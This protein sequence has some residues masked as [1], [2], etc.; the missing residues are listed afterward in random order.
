MDVW[1]EFRNASKHQ[2]EGLFRNFFPAAEEIDAEVPTQTL[3]ATSG[4][5]TPPTVP[6]TPAPSSTPTVSPPPFDDAPKSLKDTLPSLESA[7][8][9]GTDP[10]DAAR[11]AELAKIF[12]DS[13]P[14]EEFSVAELQGYLLKN[15][16]RP[17]QAAAEAPKW[18]LK[19]REMRERLAREKD[20]KEE[21]E[22]LLKEKR[23]KE[24]EEKKAKEDR[25]REDKAR[26]EKEEAEEKE[27][28]RKEKEE[29]EEKE[30][31]SAAAAAAST[32]KETKVADAEPKE[33]TVEA[34]K[35]A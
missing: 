17:E 4:T 26:K 2:A 13:I 11:L 12:A 31:A 6:G 3:F 1:I 8:S 7:S 19:E 35:E 30:K 18:V 5:P 16:A 29:K 28:A 22:R 25:E 15:K 27:K 33:A 34:P 21:K 23:R 14:D 24:R 20:E 9:L 32:E 10:L